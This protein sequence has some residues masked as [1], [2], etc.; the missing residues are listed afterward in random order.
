MSSLYSWDSNTCCPL[1]HISAY[2]H[3]ISFSVLVVRKWKLCIFDKLKHDAKTQETNYKIRACSLDAFSFLPH[4]L[5]VPGLC[6]MLVK[7][8]LLSYYWMS[9][10]KYIFSSVDVRVDFIEWKWRNFLGF[11]RVLVHWKWQIL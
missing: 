4:S 11:Y 9:Q 5:F 2:F 6:K 7:F 8:F 10:K 3:S 1:N